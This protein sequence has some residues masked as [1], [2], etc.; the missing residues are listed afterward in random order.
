MRS[1]TTPR[2]KALSL[3]STPVPFAHT[4]S[5]V[6]SHVTGWD[7]MF[8]GMVKYFTINDM[9]GKVVGSNHKINLSARF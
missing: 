8:E 3:L 5:F 4:P 1:S 2:K 9:E 6:G 7:N